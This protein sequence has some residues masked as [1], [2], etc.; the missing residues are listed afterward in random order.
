MSD[1][2]AKAQVVVDMRI[3]VFE[4]VDS[5]FKRVTQEGAWSTKFDGRATNRGSD[6]RQARSAEFKMTVAKDYVRNSC[7]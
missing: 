3:I 5:V 1:A 6:F 4:I 2:Q 7:S